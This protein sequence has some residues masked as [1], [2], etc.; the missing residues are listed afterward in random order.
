MTFSRNLYFH[1]TWTG[2]SHCDSPQ[3]AATKTVHTKEKPT[4]AE[5]VAAVDRLREELGA[6]LE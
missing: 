3:A 6:A 2:A 4:M 1:D 5:N